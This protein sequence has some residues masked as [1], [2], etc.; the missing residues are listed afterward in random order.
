MSFIFQLSELGTQLQ[1]AG[2]GERVMALMKL[3]RNK[4]VHQ[5]TQRRERCYLLHIVELHAYG[6][7]PPGGV[8]DYYL[9][10][11]HDTESGE[12]LA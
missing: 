10:A 12:N 6:W 11:L 4:I 1:K 3:V 5:N 8:R 2:V 7:V 9:H